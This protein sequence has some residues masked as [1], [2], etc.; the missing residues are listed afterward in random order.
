MYRK[1]L[2]ISFHSIILVPIYECSEEAA[3]KAFTMFNGRWYAGRQISCQ[4]CGVT[5]WK[6]AICGENT[7]WEAIHLIEYQNSS[8]IV[9]C[10]KRALCLLA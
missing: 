8:N 1:G 5:R 2:Y 10:A 4:F 7:S 6:N 3:E 9:M